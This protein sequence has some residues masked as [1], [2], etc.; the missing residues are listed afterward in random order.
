MLRILQR[1]VT[2]NPTSAR[3]LYYLAREYYYRKDYLK[4]I[5]IFEKC[6]KYSKWNPERADAHLYIA[7]CAFYS[8]QGD[9][10]REHC[11]QAINI[12]PDFKEALLFMGELHYS[13]WREKW[14]QFAQLATN[15][16]VLFV[17]TQSTVKSKIPNKLH[18]IWVGPKEAPTEWMNTW[19]EKNPDWEYTLWDNEKVFGRKWINQKHID[20]YRE[21]QIW[22]GV[23]DVVRYEILFEQG[24]F[25]PGADS[26]CLEPIDELFVD[27]FECYGVYENEKVRPGL[28]SPL[29]ACEPQCNFAKQ[30]IDGLTAKEEVGE[31]WVC[32]GNRYMQEMI[33]SKLPPIKIFPSHVFN[34]IHFTGETYKGTGKIYG[35]QMWGTTLNKY[36]N[37]V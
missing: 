27:G 19:K 5:E 28:V 10:A 1:S 18:H 17:R 15:K 29:Y 33:A 7:R 13:P 4:A 14:L 24:G 30:L 22:H 8:Q 21:K 12:N 16:D 32:T 6:L 9:K 26:I 35:K 25:M 20:Y 36:K 2:D 11:L 34:P 31:P 23:A 3:D 37:N